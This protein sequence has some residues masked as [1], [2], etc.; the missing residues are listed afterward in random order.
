MDLFSQVAVAAVTNKAALT[1]DIDPPKC[2]QL[3]ICV[4][5]CSDYLWQSK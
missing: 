5:I 1:V 2:M 4:V 3:P